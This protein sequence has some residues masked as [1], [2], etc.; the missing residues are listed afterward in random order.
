MGIADTAKKLYEAGAERATNAWASARAGIGGTAQP[1]GAIPAGVDYSGYESPPSSRG[2]KSTAG[3][4]KSYPF[5]VT[6]Y[7]MGS[8]GML[9]PN[10]SIDPTKSM[11][12]PPDGVTPQQRLSPGGIGSTPS[13]M[14]RA[15][16]MLKGKAGI[17][18]SVLTAGLEGASTY[19]DVRTPGMETSDKVARVAEGVGRGA[20]AIA[21]G[22]LGATVGSVVPVVGSAVGGLA[23]GALGYA[24]P[25]LVNKAV[26][27]FTGNDAQLASD[28]AAGLRSVAPAATPAG[29]LPGAAP[30]APSA[31]PAAAAPVARPALEVFQPGS[32]EAKTLGAQLDSRSFVPGNGEGLVRNNSTGAVTR[33]NAQ[34]QAQPAA[35]QGDEVERMLAARINGVGTNLRGQREALGQLANY[36]MQKEEL[37]LKTAIANRQASQWQAEFGDK[38]MK[39]FAEQHVNNQFYRDKVND[40]GQVIGREVDAERNAEFLNFMRNAP[41][42][43]YNKHNIKGFENITELKSEQRNKLVG[44]MRAAYLE[45]AGVEGA[46]KSNEWFRKNDLAQGPLTIGGPR[47]VNVSDIPQIGATNYAYNKLKGITFGN[48]DVVD[49]TDTAGNKKVVTATDYVGEGREGSGLRYSK[50]YKKE[51]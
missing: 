44:E 35:P 17:A 7:S 36:R 45:H 8:D 24:A 23:G 32:A 15:N 47:E 29:P 18:G 10:A 34:P 49:V 51:K 2:F 14:G 16:D 50:L 13:V 20:G 41:S 42:A 37:G 38:R 4:G 30:T 12:P 5:D 27:F 6:K 48:P 21:G 39:D 28:K 11:T 3:Q 9:K 25:D 40:K 31:P 19:R 43:F 26:N 33:I 46:S 22:A 1:A